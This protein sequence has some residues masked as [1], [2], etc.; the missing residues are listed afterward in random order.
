MSQGGSKAMFDL[1]MGPRDQEL[2][3]GAT[4]IDQNNGM[5]SPSQFIGQLEYKEDSPR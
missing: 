1:G 4:G 3:D 5:T 2:V